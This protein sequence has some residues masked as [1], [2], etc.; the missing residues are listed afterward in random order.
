M[1]A[2]KPRIG[3]IAVGRS[4]FDVAFANEIFESAWKSLH[5]LDADIIG[6][7]VL[8]FD[9]EPALAAYEAVARQGVDLLLLLQVTFTDSSVCA[10]IAERLDVPLA[11]W[12]F[13]EPR[14]GGRLRLN[15]FCGV[16]LAAHTLSR[17]K[18]RLENVHGSPDSA[19]CI[20]RIDEL[21]QAAAIV[22]K[23]AESKVLVVGEHPAGFDACNYEKQTLRQRFGVETDTTSVESFI[24]SVKALPDSI[25]DAP[26]ARRAKDFPN[27]AE[28]DQEATRKTLKVYA[29]LSSRADANGYDAI[30]VRCWPEFFTHYGCAACG[31]VALLN[32]DRRPGGCEADMFGVLSSLVLQWAAG[33][34]AFNTDLVDIDAA[35]NSVVFWHC[36]QAPIE[37]ADP[38]VQP[39]AT[40]H[41]N[42]K[43]PL[44]SEFPLKPGRITLC[45]LTQGNGKLRMMLA[46]GEM[47]R[48]PLAYSGTSGVA[49]LDVPAE[50]F[51]Q[52]LL[53]EGME[54][55]CSLSYGDHRPLLRQVARFLDIPVVE[56]A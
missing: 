23:L 29:A 1:T 55:H 52:R 26:Y 42:R 32:E 53:D 2:Q 39:R 16:N 35:G 3:V 33:K 36:G 4:T 37:M 9:A 50:T 17:M 10:R 7:K 6:D 31:A 44:L 56:L 20:A 15:S 22:R 24:E 14:T 43:L 12:T 11:V 48:A 54:H 28:M 8:Q 34:A 47:L 46:S 27:L 13:P 19:K 38:E 18:K 21:A 45:R 5:A 51:R 41:S 40:I 49:R 30:A 25:A